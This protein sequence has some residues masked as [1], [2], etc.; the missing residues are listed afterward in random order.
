[1]ATIS[2]VLKLSLAL[3]RTESVL[4][5][6]RDLGFKLTDSVTVTITDMF[7]GAANL[8]SLRH[9][10]VKTLDGIKE[11][12]SHEKYCEDRVCEEELT[13]GEFVS[14]TEGREPNAKHSSKKIHDTFS[15]SSPKYSG[16]G[17]T[18][19]SAD[20]LDLQLKIEC[21]GQIIPGDVLNSLNLGPE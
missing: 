5:A 18:L 11:T 1:M 16:V 2:K 20:G 13:C 10:S 21:Q 7:Y 8:E 12:Y 15:H 6:V 17:I 9:R 4:T 14:F 3:E 19:I